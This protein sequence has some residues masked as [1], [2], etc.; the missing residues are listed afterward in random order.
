MKIR[1]HIERLVVDGLPMAAAD[2]P[3][4]RAAIEAELTRLLV[5]QAP[6]DSWRVGTAVPRVRA[7]SIRVAAQARPVEIGRQVAR[8][9]HGAMGRTR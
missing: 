6:G 3:L 7:E 2:G 5:Q 8:S 4:L 1:L 9:V